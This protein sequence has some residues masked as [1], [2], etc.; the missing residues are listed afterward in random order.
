MRT[1]QAGW[2]GPRRRFGCCCSWRWRRL[3]GGSNRLRLPAAPPRDGSASWNRQLQACPGCCATRRRWKRMTRR[4]PNSGVGPAGCCCRRRRCLLRHRWRC[5]RAL[6]A[7]WWRRRHVS[8]RT[9][10]GWNPARSPAS[11]LR[12]PRFKRRLRRQLPSWTKGNERRRLCPVAAPCA[13]PTS[14]TRAP[15]RQCEGRGNALCSFIAPRAAP[16]LSLAGGWFPAGLAPSFRAS[17]CR[18]RTRERSRRAGD[19]GLGASGQDSEDIALQGAD[20]T[21]CQALARL[22]SNC[23]DSHRRRAPCM[24]S[25]L[26][27][28]T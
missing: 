12:G 21:L 15:A 20:L 26:E 23:S 27:S 17:V 11:W 7:F 9:R 2:Q 6:E 25:E 24:P 22:I 16:W 3:R 19:R 1:G 5:S 14:S 10:P 8:P 4:R 28:L 18:Q 13:S